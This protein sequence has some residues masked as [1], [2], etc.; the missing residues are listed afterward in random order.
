MIVDK[1]YTS[2]FRYYVEPLTLLETAFTAAGQPISFHATVDP[3]YGKV[4]KVIGGFA[5]QK[6]ICIEADSPVAAIKDIVAG[7]KIS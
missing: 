2:D 3:V 1:Q 5:S 4:I 7:V 6:I